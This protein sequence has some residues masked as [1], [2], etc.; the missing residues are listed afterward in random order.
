MADYQPSRLNLRS[1][2]IT[3]SR[4]WHYSD[5]GPVT[6][7]Q[8][9]SG[10]ITDGYKRGMRVGDFVQYTDT[11]RKLQYGMTVFASVDTGNT[12]TTLGLGVLIGDTS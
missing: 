6:D 7:V 1:Q 9:V 12:Q 10:F 4:E 8:E 5:S 11:S 3:G 2:A